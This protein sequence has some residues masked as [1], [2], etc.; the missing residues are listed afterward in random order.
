MKGAWK[1]PAQMR[2]ELYILSIILL[3]R[4]SPCHAWLP[5]TS[6]KLTNEFVQIASTKFTGN[7]TFPDHFIVL[8]QDADSLLLGG[9]NRVY[10]LSAHDLSERREAQIEWPSSEAHSQL[11]S[12]KGKG[13]DD[14]QNYVRIL[15]PTAKNKWM[16]CG[17]NSYKPM[18]R[19]YSKMVCIYINFILS[20][21]IRFFYV[22]RF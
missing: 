11:C 6:S 16:V 13:E 17:T 21:I 18:C 2:L 20:V 5:D 22:D 7:A 3:L 12:L 14:C 4:W 1:C 9:R 15:V 8:N 19:Y 10:N